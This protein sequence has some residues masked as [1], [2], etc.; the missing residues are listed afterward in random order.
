[1]TIGIYIP[2][3]Q[4]NKRR[5]LINKA[6]FGTAKFNFQGENGEFLFLFFTNLFFTIITLGFYGSW[7]ILN[8]L[9]YKLNNTNLEH[10]LKFKT[11]LRGKDLFVFS[12]LSYLV[13]VFTLGLAMPWVIDRTYKLFVNSIEVIGEIDFNQIQNIEAVG[14]AIGDVAM[15]EY[16]LDLGF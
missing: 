1:V 4:N 6:R 2:C 5:F 13:T 8:L 10:S 14:S 3:F 11:H 7:M 9:E 16:D 15:V 12:I